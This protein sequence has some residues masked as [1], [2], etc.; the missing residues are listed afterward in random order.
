VIESIRAKARRE[1]LL[2]QNKILQPAKC[3]MGDLNQLE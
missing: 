2:W 3:K 1:N